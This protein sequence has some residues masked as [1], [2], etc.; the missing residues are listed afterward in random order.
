MPSGTSSSKL[1]SHVGTKNKLTLEKKTSSSDLNPAHPRQQDDKDGIDNRQ[2]ASSSNHDQPSRSHNHASNPGDHATPYDELKLIDT[3]PKSY[4]E[5]NPRSSEDN[6]N[7]IS[8]TAGPNCNPTFLGMAVK[9]HT[10]KASRDTSDAKARVN[11]SET[12]DKD[13]DESLIIPDTPEAV[14][15]DDSDV[16]QKLC[17]ASRSFLSSTSVLCSKARRAKKAL[18][19]SASSKSFRRDISVSGR[20]IEDALTDDK[21]PSVDEKLQGQVALAGVMSDMG[22]GKQQL[23]FGLPKPDIPI[24]N[25]SEHDSSVRK[26]A[27]SKGE[28]P[29]PKRLASRTTPKKI[30]ESTAFRS[31]GAE[32]VHNA[33]TVVQSGRVWR[34][35][36]NIVD[37]AA[38][39][40][41]E[42]E[43]QGAVKENVK[44]GLKRHSLSFCDDKPDSDS[45]SKTVTPT[46]SKTRKNIFSSRKVCDKEGDSLDDILSELRSTQ[47]PGAGNVASDKASSSQAKHF[48]GKEV[49]LSK[50]VADPSHCASGST[51]LTTEITD[52]TM[53][54]HTSVYEALP[55]GDDDALDDIMNELKTQILSPP[56][57]KSRSSRPVIHQYTPLTGKRPKKKSNSERPPQSGGCVDASET[58]PMSDVSPPQL[59]PPVKPG[60]VNTAV[61]DTSRNIQMNNGLLEVDMRT[62]SLV[63]NGVESV[64][65]KVISPPVGFDT[66]LTTD[67]ELAEI[68]KGFS[69]MSPFKLPVAESE[70]LVCILFFSPTI[71]CN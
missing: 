31:R 58:S 20:T 33:K 57:N 8:D 34:N 24:C 71:M 51:T 16:K 41:S 27:R 64:S 70:W 1:F 53:T 35:P 63:I 23:N 5:N 50:H 37:S 32:M 68:A 49:D 52:A 2:V 4:D 42:E 67:T 47:S 14:S 59:N 3:A 18:G 69:Q 36:D 25:S 44:W 21:L 40:T 26:R 7:V 55:E 46:H 29:N 12:P 22:L 15:H 66:S 10:P 56:S 17:K 28:S 30:S 38:M 62:N 39:A 65:K 45:V 54:S 6:H 11:L 60:D 48:G 13:G 9:P 61:V 19:T 43:P